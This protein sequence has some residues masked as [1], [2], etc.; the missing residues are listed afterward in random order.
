M[1][2]LFGALAAALVVVGLSGLLAYSVEQR[3][4]EIG[5]RTALGATR[6]DMMAMIFRESVV[7]VA[8]GLTA[9]LP[10]ARAGSRLI[11]S[12]LFGVTSGD[13]ATFATVAVL[14]VGVGLGAGLAPASRAA[15]IDPMQALRRE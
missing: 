1:A 11:E 8:I 10:L 4:S 3:T 14:L 5:I 6:G 12:R 13:P 7:L 9:G 2:G 15:R